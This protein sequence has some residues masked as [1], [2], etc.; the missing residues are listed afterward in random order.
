[1][2]P[3]YLSATV[4]R[5]TGDLRFTITYTPIEDGWFMAQVNE[6]P[7][8]M[9]QGA[10]QEEARANA[11]DALRLMLSP[12]PGETDGTDRDSVDL[13]LAS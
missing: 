7:G 11:L 13:T 3:A 5:V 2:T 10:T 1:M 8:A 6:V 4:L 9:S 12:L